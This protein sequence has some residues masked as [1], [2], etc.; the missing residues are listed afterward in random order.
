MT[1]NTLPATR[2]LGVSERLVNEP[3]SSANS[4]ASPAE[5]TFNTLLAVNAAGVSLR[6]NMLAALVLNTPSASTD[7]P[8]PTLTPPNTPASAAGSV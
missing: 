1:F 5:L 4:I 7:K 6:D 8:L 2:A 3:P